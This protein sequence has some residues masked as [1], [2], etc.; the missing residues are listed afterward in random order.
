M[1]GRCGK[2]AWSLTHF[3]REQ[4][5]ETPR[6]FGET[7]STIH[8]FTTVFFILLFVHLSVI[9]LGDHKMQC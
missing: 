4:I 3:V 6:E 5:K 9:L 1:T 8:S 2:K 7:L